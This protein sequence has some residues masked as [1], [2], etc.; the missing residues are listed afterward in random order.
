MLANWAGTYGQWRVARR[1]GELERLEAHPARPAYAPDARLATLGTCHVDEDLRERARHRILDDTLRDMHRVAQIAR[2]DLDD[3]RLEMGLMVECAPVA[4]RGV[5][6]TLQ[7][8]GRQERS[9][10]FVA[11]DRDAQVRLR[12]ALTGGAA[13]GHDAEAGDG[14]GEQDSSARR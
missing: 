5:E 4:V 9:A 14:Q 1:A 10:R 8:V 13:R 3:E 7:R 11:A 6:P 12:A 2:L